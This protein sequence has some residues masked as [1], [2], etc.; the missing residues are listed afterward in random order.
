M[1]Y[2][3]FIVICVVTPEPSKAVCGVS[4]GKIKLFLKKVANCC[5]R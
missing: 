1:V 4:A 3:G 2:N 5:Q